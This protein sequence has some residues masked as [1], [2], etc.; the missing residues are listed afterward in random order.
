VRTLVFPLERA[1]NLADLEPDEK[2]NNGM[3]VSVFRMTSHSTRAA[4]ALALAGGLAGAPEALAQC[5]GFN[6]V[7]GVTALARHDISAEVTKIDFHAGDDPRFDVFFTVDAE[8][9]GP[10]K[11]VGKFGIGVMN[12]RVGPGQ[13][14]SA[15]KCFRF[16][17]TSLDS[18]GPY[19]ATFRLNGR[20][21]GGVL[22]QARY[23]ATLDV[24]LK[25]GGRLY[26][27]LNVSDNSSKLSERYYTDL[28]TQA[29]TI[30]GD[31]DDEEIT[32]TVEVV[33]AGNRPTGPLRAK[34]WTWGDKEVVDL[35]SI[36]AD[37]ERTL[38]YTFERPDNQRR[39]GRKT[40]LL[41]WDHLGIRRLRAVKRIPRPD[42]TITIEPEP[43]PE[44]RPE[45]V[46]YALQEVHAN[47]ASL[48]DGFFVLSSAVVNQGT[49][50][51]TDSQP[52]RWSNLSIDGQYA[53]NPLV[54][55]IPALGPNEGH[56]ILATLDLSS[57][58]DPTL[59][60]DHI[61]GRLAVEPHPGE[62][63]Q[64]N[65]VR[66]F[67]LTLC[68]PEPVEPTPPEIVSDGVEAEVL[69]P[70][71]AGWDGEVAVA[72]RLKNNGG[73]AE[74]VRWA[75]VVDGLDLQEGSVNEFEADH[76]GAGSATETEYISFDI[77]EDKHAGDNQGPIVYSGTVIGT[78]TY[79]MGEDEFAEGP[80]FEIPFEFEVGEYPRPDL[81]VTIF[82]EDS[83]GNRY[84]PAEQIF[85]DVPQ[86]LV[87]SY[88]VDNNGMVAIHR[89]DSI[90][91]S[92]SIPQY[93][94]PDTFTVE[95][96]AIGGTAGSQNVALQVDCDYW[97]GD[98]E[99]LLLTASEA[100]AEGRTSNNQ[101]EMGLSFDGS[102]GCN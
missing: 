99:N 43:E 53:F 101:A 18:S 47:V 90:D 41:V 85:T 1:A 66:E 22:P 68:R 73:D 52:V 98:R 78:T 14:A 79:R 95:G 37:E 93:R 40:K 65:N 12:A 80:S 5:S 26:R 71:Y 6:Y 87:M 9:L 50:E 70:E 34:W 67:G 56:E 88:E 13:R 96:L 23:K 46:D 57:A 48:G 89:D 76:V 36:E 91:L 86:E 35:D 55:S 59:R 30:D 32:Y 42:G 38:D 81:D 24:A 29:K 82:V 54:R 11:V 63:E 64:D 74:L 10:F 75:V 51:A 45:G 16:G 31:R 2:K 20:D 8:N 61:S 3:D 15:K 97:T 21:W 7:P 94:D 25:Q 39:F 100:P 17:P 60:A 27:D 83:S 28:V 92:W 4:L 62:T 58:E 84:V 72:V 44:P 69:D 33:N 49:D 19:K 102:H 77:P